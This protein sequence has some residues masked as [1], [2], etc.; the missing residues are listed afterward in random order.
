MATRT[1]RQ[2]IRQGWL[3]Q[4]RRL[5]LTVQT[6]WWWATFLNVRAWVVVVPKQNAASRQRLEGGRPL[7]PDGLRSALPI[8]KASRLR[9]K[10]IS[11]QDPDGSPTSSSSK[12]AASNSPKSSS[13]ISKK[14]STAAIN[15]KKTKTKKKTTTKSDKEPPY[16]SDPLDPVFIEYHQDG[17]EAVLCRKVRF[18]IRGNPLPLRRH[19]TSGGFMYNPSA[20]AQDCFRK[21]AQT[22]IFQSNN[23]T[24]L[25]TANN[26]NSDNNKTKI[27]LPKLSSP[28]FPATISNDTRAT[29]TTTTGALAMTIV[30]RTKRPLNHFVSNTRGRSLKASAPS[31]WSLTRTDVDNLAKFVL[32]SLNELLYE[33]DHQICSLCVTKVLDNQDQCL[34]ST[35]VSI[36]V[37]P[38]NKNHDTVEDMIE[39]SF[40]LYN[41]TNDAKVEGQ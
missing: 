39:K 13:K 21:I 8:Q 10:R 23:Q 29:T 15:R 37:V 30:F 22:F 7:L 3:D 2:V 40:Q 6:Y 27:T 12:L 19:R 17:K 16:W 31:A 32:D 33:D 4:C 26:N 34:G 20:N 14:V 11:S 28:L 1:P 5:L 9:G 18:K 36:S 35:E 38:N 41:I 24:I 25:C